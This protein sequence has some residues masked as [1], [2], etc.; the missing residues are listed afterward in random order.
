VI[1][2]SRQA[3]AGG[4]SRHVACDLR[5]AQRT[6]AVIRELQ[7]DVVIHTQALSD[8]DR[9]EQEPVLAHQMNVETTQ[10]LIDAL[11]GTSAFL[12][13]VS[14]DY[15]FDGRK[16]SAYDET[17]APHPIS[18]YGRVKLEAEQLAL[19][20]ARSVIIRPS[21]LFGPGRMNFCDYIVTRLKA[22]QPVEAFVD[23]VTSP[24]YTEDMAQAMAELL[25]ALT[26]HALTS[27]LPERVLH[28][29]SA[30]R[31]SR[32]EFAWR[33]AEFIGTGREHIRG[34]RM[35][36][37]RRPAMRPAY[38]ALTSRYV[39]RIIRRSLPSWDSALQAY[40]RQYHSLNLA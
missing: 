27:T 6:T 18:I 19:R 25:P 22:R 14:T 16:G 5:E 28:L 37:Q 30:G 26:T 35:A 21:T 32:V 31:C 3:L 9:C 10:H 23:Q 40:L 7:P 38:S 1:G 39:T 34:I 12:L 36:E 11:E 17:D 24:T 15:V 29:T 2:L 13:H 33:V 4:T 8:V 20:Y